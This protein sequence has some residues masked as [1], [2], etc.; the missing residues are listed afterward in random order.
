[1]RL[2]QTVR[3]P[4]NGI[5][6]P[7]SG[8]Y[9]DVKRYL[10]FASVLFCVCLETGLPAAPSTP[11]QQNAPAPVDIDAL[12]PGVGEAAPDFVLPDQN[13]QEHSLRSLLGP[14]GA[15]LVFFR[16]ADW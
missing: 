1:M 7:G 14:E 16:S 6:G 3:I 13:G 15:V 5:N 9:V 10:S 4:R 2:F 11:V 12:G 8:D